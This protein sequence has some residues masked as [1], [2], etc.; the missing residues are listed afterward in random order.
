[1]SLYSAKEELKQSLRDSRKAILG[2]GGE[3]SLTAGLKDLPE[4]IFNIPADTS[5]AFY[6]DSEMAYRKV[7]PEN[8]NPYAMVKEIGGRTKKGDYILGGEDLADSID[9]TLSNAIK[10][11]ENKTVTFPSS[12]AKAWA[13]TNLKP[14]TQYTVILYGQNTKETTNV[15]NIRIAYTDGTTSDLKFDTTGEDSYSIRCSTEGKSVEKICG[16][17]GSGTS[18]LYYE[19]CGIFEGVVTE[20]N[21][22]QYFNV[23]RSA[24]VTELKSHGAN[25]LGGEALA[26]DIVSKSAGLNN[27]SKNT[28][29]KTVRFLSTNA[30]AWK[31]TDLQP[32]TQYTIILYGYN[33]NGSTYANMRVSYSD[34]TTGEFIRF[35]ED[36][37]AI[38]QTNK[39]KSVKYITGVSNEG[40]TVLYY[41]KCGIFEGTLT[42]DDFK[43]YVGTISTL[44]IPE[45]VQSLDGYG[46]G[47]NSAHNYV[48]FAEKKFNK[49][50][51]CVDMGSLEWIYSSSEQM[52]CCLLN[53]AKSATSQTAI[54]NI[55]CD[56]YKTTSYADCK[57]SDKSICRFYATTDGV[58]VKDSTYTD[59]KAFR[60]AMSGVM[61][62]YE[63]KTPEITDI[64]DL[65][66]ND[67][68]IEVEGGGTITAVNKYEYAVPT[69]I[70]Y[71]RRV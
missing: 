34:G 5:L 51:A 21:M 3:I 49:Q 54:A 55:L 32:N 53:K 69:T 57:S 24:K 10:D 61:L 30:S 47:V 25:L 15:T 56:K 64:S 36:G 31:F 27:A 62:Y 45:A 44:S 66:T 18:L 9:A 28:E 39:A 19:K 60:A 38:Y 65:F 50:V 17:T 40:T 14:N 22:S 43:E 35:S 6:E 52:F 16:I 8:V 71:T 23:I 1:M 20:E 70:K 4:A 58:N 13:F 26:D 11:T 29:D 33:L 7:V 68:L 63:L 12:T 48:D 67:N 42:V 2:R 37:Y 59:A 46:W 41:E